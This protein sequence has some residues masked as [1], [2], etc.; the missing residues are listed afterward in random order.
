[1]KINSQITEIQP[2]LGADIHDNEGNLAS[3][4]AFIANPGSKRNK[5]CSC[6]FMIKSLFCREK[7]IAESPLVLSVPR[8]FSRSVWP[9]SKIARATIKASDSPGL[10]DMPIEIIEKII[11]L[12]SACAAKLLHV[13]KNFRACAIAKITNQ[14]KIDPN[15][16]LAEE[17]IKKANA[18]DFSDANIPGV[19]DVIRNEMVGLISESISERNL[20]T[21]IKLCITQSQFNDVE[22]NPGG[23]RAFEDCFKCAVAQYLFAANSICSYQ[24]DLSQKNSSGYHVKNLVFYLKN[25]EDDPAALVSL[26]LEG[27]TIYEEHFILLLEI[28][29]HYKNLKLLN[30]QNISIF[31]FKLW[32]LIFSVTGSTPLDKKESDYLLRVSEAIF[33]LQEALPELVIL[34]NQVELAEKP[35]P[36]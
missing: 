7:V 22:K 29:G 3:E 6:F 10:T 21:C 8:S 18:L 1:M 17:L 19:R 36:C 27:S 34:Q 25:G 16:G 9:F 26:D 12:D 28:L 32:E 2:L 11:G 5:D 15:W 23:T 33:V 30:I 20:S 31:N 4:K 13:S 35:I 24:I 14:I